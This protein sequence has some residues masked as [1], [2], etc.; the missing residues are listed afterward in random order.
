M[1]RRLYTGG[2]ILT[3][4]GFVSG[5]ELLTENG[6]I[7]DIATGLAAQDAEIVNLDGD[8]LVPGYIDVQVNGGGGVL[9]NDDPSVAG[10]ERLA[11]A[12]RTFGTTSL[13]P[14]LISDD[15]DVVGAGIQA[16]RDAIIQGV[17][18][19]RGIHIEGPVLN[20]RK[21]G[22]HDP[23]RFIKLDDHA[24][25]ILTSLDNGQTIVTL[26][27]ERCSAD[28]IRY[29]VD[30]GVIVSLGHTDGGYSDARQA[31]DAGATGFTHLFNAMSPIT[32]REPGVVGAAFDDHRAWSSLIVDGLHVDPVVLNMAVRLRPEDR[33]ILITDAMSNT[34][35]DL[36]HFYL[37]GRRITVADGACRDEHGILAG[38]ALS[39][40]QAVQNTVNKLALPPERAI[41][42]ASSFPADFLGLSAERGRLAQGLRADLV[43]L[44]TT[45]DVVG[46]WSS[47]QDRRDAGTTHTPTER[48]RSA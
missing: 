5:R 12:H 43:R 14:T 45:L 48:A 27:P 6:V 40:G 22:I 11:A 15:L 34:G 29:L 26:A 4:A 24:L 13:M 39:M 41:R 46:V 7:V 16:V 37:Q 21:C 10:L 8:M 19:I 30:A 18:G 32:S 44:D 1:T 20:P 25:D 2:P 17:P 42:M 9:F 33:L 28:H 31:L 36:D 3:D 47:D 23:A 35:T 38:A